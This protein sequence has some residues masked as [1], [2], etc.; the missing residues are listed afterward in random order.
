MQ[1]R[2]RRVLSTPLGLTAV[3]L[4]VV[5]TALAVLG[6]VLWGSGADAVDTDAILAQPSAAHWAGTDILGRDI[7]LRVLVATRLSVALALIA[8]VVAVVVGL[9]SGRR[10]WSRPPRRAG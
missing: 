9:R 4:M 7:L 5:I 6:P 1:G 2:W 10:R 8:I 3:V